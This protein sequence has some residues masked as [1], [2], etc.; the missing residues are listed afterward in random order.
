M[1]L[2]NPKAGRNL[3]FL[4]Y[5]CPESLCQWI[6]SPLNT[7]PLDVPLYSVNMMPQALVGSLIHWQHHF[8]GQRAFCQSCTGCQH[9]YSP[10]VSWDKTQAGPMICRRSSFLENRKPWLWTAFCCTRKMLSSL[11]SFAL[12]RNRG[13]EQWSSS[14]L[15]P[16]TNS[17][18]S[19]GTLNKRGKSLAPSLSF[20]FIS[21]KWCQVSPSQVFAWQETPN[22]ETLPARGSFSLSSTWHKTHLQWQVTAYILL[23]RF[24]SVKNVNKNLM[25][26]KNN[27]FQIC[28]PMSL[29]Q[30]ILSYKIK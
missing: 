10:L 17:W 5:D 29:R 30:L 6:I 19:M 25:W 11:R 9:P 21:E 3:R 1:E 12:Q 7:L 22:S 4:Y 13:P 20:F 23:W 8:N 16:T 14:W 24:C 2:L 15:F 26:K 27:F 18:R 28:V